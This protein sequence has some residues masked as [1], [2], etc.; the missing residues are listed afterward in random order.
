MN[1]SSTP[2]I[3]NDYWPDYNDINQLNQRIDEVENEISLVNIRLSNDIENVSNNLNT[4]VNDQANTTIT[5]NLIVNNLNANYA[6]GRFANFDNTFTNNAYI[7]NLTVNKPVFDITLN[8][9]HLENTT[10]LNGNFY[11]PNLIGAK[12]SGDISGDLNV[13]NVN[14]LNV[15]DATIANLFVNTSATPVQSSAVLGYDSEGRVIPIRATFDVGFPEDA[16]YLFTDHAGTAFAGTAATEVDTSSNLITSYGVKNAIDALNADVLDNFNLINNA[17]NDIDEWENTFENSVANSFNDVNNFV[18]DSLNA[19]NSNLDVLNNNISETNNTLK[20]LIEN[21]LTIDTSGF[22]NSTNPINIQTVTDVEA[23]RFGSVPA[24]ATNI[25]NGASMK[26]DG[27][28]LSIYIPGVFRKQENCHDMFY[29]CK[30]L[31]SNVEIPKDAIDCSRM[32]CDCFNLNQSINI[33]NTVENCY[34]MFQVCSRLDQPITVPS[35]AVNCAGMFSYCENLDRYITV[36]NGVEVCSDMF[37][38]CTNLKHLTVVPSSAVN[39]AGMFYDCVQYNQPIAIPSNATDCYLMFAQC[40][41]LNQD[42]YIYSENITNMEG[43]FQDCTNMEGKQVHIRSSIPLD[44]S[45]AIYNSLVNGLTGVNFSGNVINDLEEPIVWPPEIQNINIQEPVASFECQLQE[46]DVT[47][48]TDLPS[49]FTKAEYDENNTLHASVP[50]SS[51]VDWI[52]LS[53]SI[54]ASDIIDIHDAEFYLTSNGTSVSNTITISG[55]IPVEDLDP[56]NF[57]I[58]DFNRFNKN[59]ISLYGAGK[60]SQLNRKANKVGSKSFNNLTK[61]LFTIAINYR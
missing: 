37:S 22:I 28:K 13:V 10:S 45:N 17:L 38:T 27:T 8:T 60:I 9:P 19:V 15:I 30:Y 12:F 20:D 3:R 5:N 1:I 50:S 53:L 42:V 54:T 55:N 61:P 6:E 16:D 34:Q 52:A 2:F 33:P 29:R 18:N 49:A 11:S 48:K 51:L 41:N 21:Y 36:S 39:C 46:Q 59:T 7:E 31:N 43:M 14:Q 25:G 23:V 32:F 56:L 35:S 4:Y 44:T 26:L 40:T 24:D 57:D 58:E 47:V